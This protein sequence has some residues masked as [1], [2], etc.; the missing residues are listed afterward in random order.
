V[1]LTVVWADYY[2][3]RVRTRPMAVNR[4]HELTFAA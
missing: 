1:E 2:W 4:L 3:R